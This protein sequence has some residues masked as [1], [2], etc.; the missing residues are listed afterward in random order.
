LIAGLLVKGKVKAPDISA[1]I[2]AADLIG[3]FVGTLVFS[4]F[5]LPFLGIF[6]SLIILIFLIVFS[7][8]KS[9]FS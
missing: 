3:A 1:F 7:G 9:A 5:L 6:W 2:Y 4:I 8:L